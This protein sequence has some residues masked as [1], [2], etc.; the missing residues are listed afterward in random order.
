M[1]TNIFQ[2]ERLTFGKLFAQFGLPLLQSHFFRFMDARNFCFNFFCIVLFSGSFYFGG[3]SFTRR[4]TFHW[5]HLSRL[6]VNAA[7]RQLPLAAIYTLSKKNEKRNNESVNS[8]GC[9]G[10]VTADQD[11]SDRLTGSFQGCSRCFLEGS[12]VRSAERSGGVSMSKCGETNS[13]VFAPN[14][15]M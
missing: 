14:G 3:R 13:P 7:Y 1:F 5:K 12:R 4:C 9:A 15:S 11:F 6:Y 2:P 10:I 8:A